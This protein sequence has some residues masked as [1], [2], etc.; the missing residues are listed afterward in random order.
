MLTFKDA[1]GDE[2][3]MLMS[4]DVA[5]FDVLNADL[6]RCYAASGL[7]AFVRRCAA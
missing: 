6:E 1:A 3:L 4:E 5:G 7:N 2:G